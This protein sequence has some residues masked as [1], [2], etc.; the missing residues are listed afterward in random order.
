MT[1]ALTK[2]IYKPDHTSTSE[3]TVIVNPEEFK[4]WKDGD[5]SIPLSEVVDSFTVFHSSQG[6][7]GFLGQASQQQLDT[8]FG[9][10]KNDE[11]VKEIL[12]KG[13]DQAS[14]SIGSLSGVSTNLSRGRASLD[15]K[16][17]GPLNF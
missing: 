1:K 9:T 7:S 8:D 3:Y 15:M 14:D 13:R 6:R 12:T 11:I 4:K 17:K 10:V 2:V 5:T 16:G